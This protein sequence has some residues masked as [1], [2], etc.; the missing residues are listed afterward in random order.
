MRAILVEAGVSDG[1]LE[2]GSLRCDANVSVR[3]GGS[4]ALGERTE[5]KNLNS[6]RFLQRAIAYEAGRQR[7]VIEAGGGDRDGDACRGTNA[8]A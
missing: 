8:A 2:D 1:N 4:A 6:F 3:L 7:A 5:I